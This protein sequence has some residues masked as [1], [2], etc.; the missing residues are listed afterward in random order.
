MT[1]ILLWQLIFG[2]NKP[3]SDND[4]SENVSDSDNDGDS[5]DDVVLAVLLTTR[6]HETER[7]DS[8]NAKSD[9]VDAR[10]EFVTCDSAHQHQ[11]MT[12]RVNTP[13]STR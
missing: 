2:K 6:K 8:S 11:Y 5:D 3:K 4:E 9:N 10:G 1:T 7:S 13:S 12:V